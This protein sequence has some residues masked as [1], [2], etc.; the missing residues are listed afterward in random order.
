MLYRWKLLYKARKV[1]CN[2][3][4][5]SINSLFTTNVVYCNITEHRQMESA[6][7][8]T[9]FLWRATR[10]VGWPWKFLLY[11]LSQLCRTLLDYQLLQRQQGGLDDF[12]NLMSTSS[13][14]L[15]ESTLY[16][17]QSLSCWRQWWKPLK[18][19]WQLFHHIQGHLPFFFIWQ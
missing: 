17:S 18:P 11:R 2:T 6:G 8:Y 3:N 15:V 4:N 9:N 12:A 1:V 16:W 14:W 19:N 7:H 5:V 13:P 10:T